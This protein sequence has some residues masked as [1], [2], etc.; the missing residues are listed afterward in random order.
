MNTV[1][2]FCGNKNLSQKRVRYI[3]QNNG[4]YFFVDDV[5]C[6]QCDYCGE[7]YF[8]AKEI[9]KIENAFSDII[10]HKKHTHKKLEIPVE[11]FSEMI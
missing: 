11:N 7:Q 4:N 10:N 3:Y 5:P 1:C 6:M 8:E 2:A 9:I